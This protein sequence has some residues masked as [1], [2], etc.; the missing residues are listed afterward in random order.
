MLSRSVCVEY[1]QCDNQCEARWRAIDRAHPRRSRTCKRGGGAL[2][3]PVCASA[4]C[5]VPAE[6]ALAGLPEHEYLSRQEQLDGG[7]YE[8]SSV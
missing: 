7:K 5:T 3:H 6:Y 4:Y 2:A 1:D 8:Y